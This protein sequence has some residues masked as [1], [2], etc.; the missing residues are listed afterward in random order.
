LTTISA[1]SILASQHTETGARIDTFLL[2]YP[3]WIH[4]EFMTH[5]VFS[6]NASSS[7]AI[8]VAKLIQSVID[9]PAVP[10]FWGANQKGMQADVECNEKVGVYAKPINDTRG[11]GREFINFERANMAREDAWIYARDRAIEAARAFDEAG[12]HKQI[13]NRLLEP[14]GH[15]TVVATG[16]Q[17]S[18]F[19][20]L[21]CHPAAEPHMQM[22]ARAIKEAYD[23]AEVQMLAPGQWHLP[24]VGLDDWVTINNLC[25]PRGEHTAMALK[26]SVARCAST[27]YKTVEG[28]D[29]TL[30][31][32]VALHDKLVASVPLH[33][34]P[35]EHQAQADKYDGRWAN[36]GHGGNLGDGWIQYRKLLPGECQ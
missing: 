18:N 11:P 15:I 27:S 31:R 13:V 4:A 9:D 30:E 2:R 16:T 14:F 3:R 10:L 28:F 21:R 22:L 35:C 32:A 17:W 23:E 25:L 29:M 5:R 19:F 12:Y 36:P 1:K 33:A 24:F 6:R 20:A 26:L 7:R 34:S 8:P